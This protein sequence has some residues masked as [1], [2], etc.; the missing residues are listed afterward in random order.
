MS[1][2]GA[3]GA[4]RQGLTW[5]QIVEFYYPGTSW[6]Q[7]R[8]PVRVLITADTSDDV[9][10]LAQA[11][12]TVTRLTAAHDVRAARP[13]ARR[14]G[15][16]RPRRRAA[17]QV[18]VPRADGW[19][20]AGR[21]SPATASSPPAAKR[22]AL[23]TP[24][25][26]PTLPRPAPLGHAG[27]RLARRATPS[28]CLSLDAYLKGVVPLEIPALVEPERGARP[29]G[30]GP[31]VRGVRARAPQR[32]AL[33]DLRHHLVP[34]VRR[35]RRRAPGRDA[36][37]KATAAAGPDSTTASRRSPSSPRAAAA[38]PRPA[39]RP[40]SSRR[41]TRTTAGRATRSTPGRS[42][43]D[44]ATLERHCPAIG[45]LTSIEVT[46]RDGNGEWGGRVRSMTLVGTARPRR[47]LRRHLP[48]RA[49]PAVDVVHL[50]A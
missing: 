35:L 5:Q 22:I 25:R 18:A 14:G 20:H 40:T 33:P 16:S 48:L 31:H 47:H 23:V 44:D 11:G 9:V 30:R 24:A 49:R 13:T 6:G 42:T 2:Y 27:A 43:V 28:T 38:G 15:G 32:R 29:G 4:A 37:I 1:Q 10:V 41:R 17:A 36:A 50:H 7:L 46:T 8:G 34:G 39:R 26:Q 45:D 12:L 3:E 19:Q 21:P